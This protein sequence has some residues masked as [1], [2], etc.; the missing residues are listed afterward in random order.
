MHVNFTETVDGIE[1][2]SISCD[3]DSKTTIFSLYYDEE[4]VAYAYAYDETDTLYWMGGAAHRA[5]IKFTG[6]SHIRDSI[7]IEWCYRC[8]ELVQ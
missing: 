2:E 8:A 3:Y 7:L 5:T 6:G 4:K 1:H